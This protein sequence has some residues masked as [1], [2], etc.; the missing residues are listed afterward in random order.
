[1]KIVGYFE[2]KVL[3]RNLDEAEKTDQNCRY[4]ATLPN[5]VLTN[6]IEFRL[7][8]TGN[9][10]SKV[11]ISQLKNIHGLRGTI[12]IEGEKDLE[13]LMEK[14]FSFSHPNT[15]STN[16]LAIELAKRTIGNMGLPGFTSEQ[17]ITNF[18]IYN[19]F[20][21]DKKEPIIIPQDEGCG[22]WCGGHCPGAIL[23]DTHCAGLPGPMSC[24]DCR[25]EW[26]QVILSPRY[27]LLIVIDVNSRH[28]AN[29]N[30]MI[31]MI[32]LV[33]KIH[34]ANMTFEI[35]KLQFYLK[36]GN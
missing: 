25:C 6:F 13:T 35:R 21:T 26:G 17:S 11:R 1:M 20:Y 12:P 2:A 28:A 24:Q 36:C 10:V 8:K 3:E 23:T 5:F 31:I 16:L 19:T 15:T 18:Y 29:H 32:Q 4:I 9:C 22:P 7:Y 30:F 34:K 33:Y 27:V 14:F